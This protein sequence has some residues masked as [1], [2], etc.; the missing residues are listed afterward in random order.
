MDGIGC[1]TEQGAEI[2][3]GL[4][5]DELR[6]TA[7]DA[8]SLHLGIVTGYDRSTG[9]LLS[10]V[11]GQVVDYLISIKAD[12]DSSGVG[13]GWGGDKMKRGSAAGKWW[14]DSMPG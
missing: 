7:L 10:C 6:S 13:R 9:Q 3:F 1:W 8:Y 2:V 11:D 5:V 12:M 14:F 4:L